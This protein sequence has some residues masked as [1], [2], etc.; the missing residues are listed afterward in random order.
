MKYPM[1]VD[2][3][4]Q[5]RALP[6]KLPQHSMAVAYQA[7]IDKQVP[8]AHGVEP[9]TLEHFSIIHWLLPAK[10]YGIEVAYPAMGL[11]ENGTLVSQFTNLAS[12]VTGRNVGT[13]NNMAGNNLETPRGKMHGPGYLQRVP[14]NGGY[15]FALTEKGLAVLRANAGIATPKAKAAAKAAGKPAG[16][17]K[18]K[19]ATPVA[20]EVETPISEAATGNGGVPAAD[21]LAALAEHF[22][23]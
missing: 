5:R 12:L 18:P 22:N 13:A 21:Q 20:V 6:F 17:R 19:P 10:R 14:H 7:F 3:N 9:L 15:V 2:G 11:R 1:I 8:A 23:G 16:K 4:V